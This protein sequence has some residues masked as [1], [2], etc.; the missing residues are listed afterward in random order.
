MILTFLIHNLK[1]WPNLKEKRVVVN[2]SGWE[3]VGVD[4]NGWEWMGLDVSG[5]EWAGVDGSWWEHGLVQPKENLN[6]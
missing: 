2:V 5:W 4:G 3:W 6:K 1:K